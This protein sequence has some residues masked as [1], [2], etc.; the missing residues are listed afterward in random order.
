MTTSSTSRTA[1]ERCRR[2]E[3]EN[4]LLRAELERHGIA[5]PTLPE[6][7]VADRGQHMSGAP[8]SADPLPTASQD[9]G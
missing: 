7:E 5:L 6:D 8:R 2:L 9:G 4:R 3:L 1:H